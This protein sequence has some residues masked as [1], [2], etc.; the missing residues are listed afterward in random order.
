MNNIPPNTKTLLNLAAI[1]AAAPSQWMS[2]EGYRN[3]SYTVRITCTA[4]ITGG[5][6]VMRGTNYTPQDVGCPAVLSFTAGDAPAAAGGFALSG[7]TGILA[8]APTGA[9]TYSATF[10]ALSF[11]KFLQAEVL[12]GTGGGTVTISVTLAGW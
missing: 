5:Q 3:A 8:F 4:A 10:N 6:L 9:G 1:G 2:M 12:A 11:P 7:T